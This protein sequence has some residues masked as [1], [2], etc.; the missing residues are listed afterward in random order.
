M[1]GEQDRQQAHAPPPGRRGSGRRAARAADRTL[2]TLHLAVRIAFGAAT[3]GVLLVGLVWLRL[4][5]GPIH[6]PLAAAAAER[7]FNAGSDRLRAEAGDV[8][9]TLGERGGPAGVQF[10][11]V[12][13]SYATGEPLFVIPRLAARFDVR[14]LVQGRLRPVR[15]TLVRPEAR[16]ERTADGRFRFGLGPEVEAAGSAPDADALP[17]APLQFAAVG[18]ILDSLAGDAEPVPELSRL[19]EIVIRDADLTFENAAAGRRW[20]TRRADFHVW[21]SAAGLRARMEVGLA[22][23]SEAGAAA[24]VSAERRRGAGGATRIEARFDGL[25]PEHLAEQLAQMEWLRLFDAPLDG[26]LEATIHPDG[27]V[28]DLA[29]RIVAGPGRVLALGDGGKPFD[30]ATLD[31]A[32]EAGRERMRVREFALAGPEAEARLSGF[33]ELRRDREGELTGL[34]GQFDVAGLRAEVP[35]VFADPLAFDDGQIVARLSLDPLGIEV[36]RSHLRAG[37]LTIEVE[38]RARAGADG[39]R[40]GLR[41]AGRNMSIDRLVRLWPHVAAGN[42]RRWVGQNIRGG[43]VDAFVAHLRFGG[44]RPEVDL[45][46]TYSDLESSYLQEMTPIVAASGRGSLTLN[47]FHLAMESGEVRPVEGAPVRLDGS[48]MR[49]PDLA[50][51]PAVA[52]I[53]LRGQGPTAHVLTLIDEAPLRLTSRLGLVPESVAGEA[54]VTA[55]LSF[56]LIDELELGGV[57]V[58][59]EATLHRL[60]LPFR[61]PGGHLA[62]VRGEQVALRADPREMRVAGPVLVD[63]TPLELEWNEYYGRGAE[64]RDIALAGAVTPGFLT[65]LDLDTEYFAGGSATIALGLEQRGSPDL[66]FR[67]E[68][69]LGPAQLA[70]GEF[71]WLKPPGPAGQLV[72]E[73]TFG[74][75]IEVPDF[76]LDTDELKAE[77]AIT[78]DAAGRMLSATVERLR[79][80]SLADVRLT[81]E[82]GA[83]PARTLHLGVGGRRLDL[84]LFEDDESGEDT[85]AGPGR[86]LVVRFNLDE[87]V[88]TPKV[89]ARPAAG[90]Y[91]RDAQGLAS[92]DL[93]GAL[94]GRVP[95]AADYEKTPGEPAA[96]I[97]RA[98]DAGALL[99]EAGL[100]GA[101]EGGR[102]RLRARLAPEAGVDLVGVARIEDVR[103]RGGGTF[104]SILAEG[105]AQEAASA[106]ETGGLTFD[107]VRVPFEY[108]DGLMVLGE[109]LA[110]GN[111][112]AVKV[113][114]TVDET[115][116][117]VDLVGVISPAYGLTGALDSIPL[118]GTILSG[119]KG[120]GIVAMTFQVAGTLDAPRF[121]VNPLSLLTPGILRNIFSG[122]ATR[123]NERF[124]DQLGRQDN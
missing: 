117:A 6:L 31:F 28:E 60:A 80:Q 68:A 21:R 86:P 46:F 53:T 72:A 100:F 45:D 99:A 71:D 70:V 39:W 19:E 11:D 101:A 47:A 111:M 87:L 90:S 76:R 102:L 115:S 12:R 29:G 98:D 20:Q 16:L 14:D 116:D 77:G 44:A 40:S 24:V 51:S 105:G 62:D 57:A 4:A 25:R 114:G 97:V 94:G 83:D 96:V 36:A 10:V 65:R 3:L 121:T 34:A 5:H 58:R 17:A 118:I 50:A 84:A 81:A 56:P 8:V 55:E 75:G 106:A 23:G 37:E 59:A 92:A 82:S 35:E 54:A 18:R 113:E 108:R 95:F 64:H 1:A 119:G 38:G 74:A 122:R 42:A 88:I 73:G 43:R 30:S 52:Q 49:I 2:H 123:P 104:R 32:Y 85:G 26:R 61:L 69:D 91:R 109:S 67:L 89:V 78:F 110:R 66:A 112:L 27:R 41:A 9:L 7:I 33:A 124:L 22:D 15:I 63:G 107:T 48:V 79:F 120:E 93:A 103:I 13:L